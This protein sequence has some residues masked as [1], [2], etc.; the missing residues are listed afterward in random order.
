MYNSD[1]YD[2][3][4]KAKHL[5][6]GALMLKKSS[7][8]NVVEK[9]YNRYAFNDPDDLPSWF[10]DDES[11]HHR[12]ILP[13]TKEM[14]EAAKAR[15]TDLA[16]PSNQ[17]D[18]RSQGSKQAKGSAAVGAYS[19]EGRGHRRAGRAYQQ[20][21]GCASLKS[22]TRN[23]RSSDPA[24]SSSSTQSPGVK[25]QLATRRAPRVVRSSSSTS[26]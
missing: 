16:A 25:A 7:R 8:R 4:E 20:D 14:V 19:K 15:F 24:P 12:P 9:A 22:S 21:K 18:R 3:D 11:E 1:E 5:A 26:A 10:V 2:S 23:P 17:E 6:L 13:I